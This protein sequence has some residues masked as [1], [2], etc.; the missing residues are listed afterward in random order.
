MELMVCMDG[1]EVR[2]FPLRDT[3]DA[4]NAGQERAAIDLAY[5]L[6][7]TEPDAVISVVVVHND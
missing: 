1:A 4:F 5:E 2:N 6:K 7:E 3:A